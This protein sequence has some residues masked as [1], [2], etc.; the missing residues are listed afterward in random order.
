M[1]R[2]DSRDEQ[3]CPPD[4]QR[5]EESPAGELGAAVYEAEQAEWEDDRKSDKT[6]DARDA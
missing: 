6:A 2:L 1:D 4:R 5:H 3:G